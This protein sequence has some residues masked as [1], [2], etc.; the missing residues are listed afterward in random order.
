MESVEHALKLQLSN[1]F[2][3]DLQLR[4]VGEEA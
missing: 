3:D 1:L 2:E 4:C